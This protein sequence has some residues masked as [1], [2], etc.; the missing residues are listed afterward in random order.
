MIRLIG[1]TFRKRLLIFYRF[2]AVQRFRRFAA[3]KCR[4]GKYDY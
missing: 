2:R 1:F 4:Y 3:V